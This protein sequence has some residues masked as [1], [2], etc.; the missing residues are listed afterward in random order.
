M[1][2]RLARAMFQTEEL[3]RIG[4]YELLHVLGKG[5]TSTVY[6]AFDPKLQR[7]VALKLIPAGL[8]GDAARTDQRVLEEARAVA[9]VSHPNV[10]KVHEVDT[11]DEGDLFL[12]MELV[13]GGTLRA[14]NRRG[15]GDPRPRPWKEVV[16]MYVAA[17][18]GL[19]AVHEAGFVHR[20]FKPEN[21]L[22]GS[23]GVPRVTDL[24]LA[25][26]ELATDVDEP[27]MEG[28]SD[29]FVGATRMTALMAAG[30]PAYMS[31][32]QHL[33]Q[34]VDGRSDQFSFCAALW[35]ALYGELPFE[36]V[37]RGD[38][39]ENVLS[40]RLRNPRQNSRVP[41]WLRSALERGLCK[42]PADRWATL[43]DL[44]SELRRDRGLSYRISI[45]AAIVG[46]TLGAGYVAGESFQASVPVA[47]TVGPERVHTVWNPDRKQAVREGVLK[48]G[49]PYARGTSER[50]DAALTEYVDDWKKSLDAVCDTNASNW[51]PIRA[52]AVS[53]CL[54]G[55]LDTLTEM[56]EVLERANETVTKNAVT[57]IAQL[58]TPRSCVDVA[59]RHVVPP[60]PDQIADVREQ[61]LRIA[62]SR[63]LA[64][65]GEY[66]GARRELGFR[67]RVTYVPVEAAARLEYGFTANELAQ[68]KQ[69]STELLAATYLAKGC[70]E[71]GIAAEAA[72]LRLSALNAISVRDAQRWHPVALELAREPTV[73]AVV[74]ANL[75]AEIGT[76]QQG[77]GNHA[78]S[79]RHLKQAL[80]MKIVLLGPNDQDVGR[81]LNNLGSAL[82]EYGALEEATGVL[83][84]AR[85]N[86]ERSLG[87][88]H[89]F[90]GITAF[91]LSET[92]LR[93]GEFDRTREFLDDAEEILETSSRDAHFMRW[94]IA[95]SRSVLALEDGDPTA[96]LRLAESVEEAYT[97]IDGDPTVL[98]RALRVKGEAYSTLGE[99]E[100][101]L[102]LLLRAL[103]LHEGAETGQRYLAELAL[104]KALRGVDPER[105]VRLATDARDRFLTLG[106]GWS[107]HATEAEAFLTSIRRVAVAG[108]G[109]SAEA[110]RNGR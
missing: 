69:S 40:G 33:G 100:L 4:R 88:L 95:T 57:A 72:V 19:A 86:F 14:W 64:V 20:D 82:E 16:R 3:T 54:L 35:E 79:I 105:A 89:P 74:R 25:R 107:R 101:A 81:T 34:G 59:R 77:L 45:A 93:L 29:A 23:D 61:R 5:A 109:E 51:D 9:K 104:A 103:A 48:T 63:A 12:S 2:Q 65:A 31:P 43:G 32:E 60:G 99:P 67:D 90:V 91:N 22:V 30:T 42:A 39:R 27:P 92:S 49:L 52:D 47:C 55:R 13:D 53:R 1:M 76:L 58:R 17:G 98:A 78:E 8:Y 97:E 85:A 18:R 102:P 38:L 84:A 44:L 41:N 15:E 37:T 46:A 110:P 87:E 68:Y 36:G 94:S 24:G 70:G 96:A 56:T 6:A 26:N 73:P 11:T 106:Q 21:V 108:D 66:E 10:I 71:H 50:I 83:Q 62:K 75:E 28:L 80:L 7:K